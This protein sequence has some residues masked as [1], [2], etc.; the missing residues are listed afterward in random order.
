MLR[1]RRAATETLHQLDIEALNIELM[2]KEGKLQNLSLENLKSTEGIMQLF[3]VRVT[4]CPAGWAR[5][6]H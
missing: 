4:C 1:V 2:E 5:L 6:V 3:M